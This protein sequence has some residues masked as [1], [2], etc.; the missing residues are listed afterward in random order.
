VAVAIS[1]AKA[2]ASAAQKTAP[3]AVVEATEDAV[4]ISPVVPE[5]AAFVKPIRPAKQAASPRPAPAPQPTP[6]QP[7]PVLAVKAPAPIS[8]PPKPLQKRESTLDKALD[9]VVDFVDGAARRTRAEA[10]GSE[11]A[12]LM[13]KAARG[14]ALAAFM[15]AL[16][17]GIAPGR[18]QVMAEEVG[19]ELAVQLQAVRREMSSFG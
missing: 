1:P 19:V 10:C 2:L 5:Q 12:R 8:G 11:L 16:A 3:D 9:A 6:P 4:G 15:A 7:E 13:P 14:P 18:L 17:E